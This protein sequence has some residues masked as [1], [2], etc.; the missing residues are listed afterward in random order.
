LISIITV[1]ERK[2]ILSRNEVYLGN[3]RVEVVL[4]KVISGG[5]TG[6]DRAGLDAAIDAGIS[7]GGYCPK[8]RIA[9]DGIIPDCYPLI[10][11]KTSSYTSR[12]EKN[13]VESDGTLIL[14]KGKLTNGTRRTYEYTEEHHKPCMI[15]QFD[16]GDP[17]PA[18]RILS[19]LSENDIK[20][21]NIAGPRESKTIEGIY[22]DVKSLLDDI[23]NV[24]E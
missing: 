6:V 8:G 18:K 16:A 15:V 23:F 7:I 4:K 9:E 13:V 17:E 22:D 20:T 21:L 10:E 14:N 1:L 2:G 19:W 5:Q 11:I 24:L 12:T 3:K